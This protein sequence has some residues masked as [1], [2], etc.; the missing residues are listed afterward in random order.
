MK[1]AYVLGTIALVC[2]ATAG[3]VAACSTTESTNIKTSG[4]WV[5][6]TVEHDAHDSVTVW[7]VLR[8]G[9]STG[10]II[11]LFAGEHLEVNG[12]NMTEWVEPITNYH[13]SRAVIGPDPDGIYDIDFVRLGDEVVST[14]V[15]TPERPF[16]TSLD[17]GNV[18]NSEEVLT[19]Y[20]DEGD[21][22]DDVDIYI[23]GDCIENHSYSQVADTG[24]FV[25]DPIFDLPPPD[26]PADCTLQVTV[27][28]NVVGSV[29]SA[30]QGGYT[31]ARAFEEVLIAFETLL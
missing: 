9:G 31:E 20:W 6:Y 5:R 12:T 30:F 14:T 15:V 10:T 8:V 7:G 16:I 24:M 28:R 29:N 13:W 2:L 11:D 27:A 21:P 1:R 18:V 3:L 25:S 19:I 23:E 26:L 4:I 22:G 17:P